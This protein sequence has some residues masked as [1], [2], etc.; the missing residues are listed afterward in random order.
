M[1]EKDQVG[2]DIYVEDSPKNLEALRKAGHFAICIANST[3]KAV[4]SP[5]ADTWDQVYD[6]VRQHAPLKP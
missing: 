5:P 1:K 4:G 3:N 6:L 2:A